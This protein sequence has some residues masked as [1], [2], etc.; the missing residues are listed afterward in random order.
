[1]IERGHFRLTSAISADGPVFGNRCAIKLG[2]WEARWERGDCAS[3]PITFSR[4]RFHYRTSKSRI[5]SFNVFA[6]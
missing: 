4:L 5:G 2:E 1:M 3:I 6:S